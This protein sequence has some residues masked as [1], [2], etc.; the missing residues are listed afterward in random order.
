MK[1]SISID[2]DNYAEY[3]SLIDP[4]RPRGPSF[5]PDAL[6]RLLDLL[7]RHRLR[8]TFFVIG[9]DAAR[10]EHRGLLQQALSAGHELANH[11]FSHP[12]NFRALSPETRAGEIDRAGEA[13]AQATGRAPVG[14]RTPS[15]DVDGITLGLLEERGYAYDASVFPSPLMWVFRL[16]GRAV[17]RRGDYQL[18]E[19]RMALAPGE[20]YFPSRRCIH[21]GAT[22]PSEDRFDLPELPLSVA[23][24]L[25]I[26]FYSTL[27]RRGGAGLFRR[28]VGHHGRRARRLHALF[29]LVEAADLRG[30]PLEAA[31]RRS[32]GL[33][34]PLEA[35]LRFLDGAFAALAEAGESVTLAEVAGG[36]RCGGRAARPAGSDRSASG[37]RLPRIDEPPDAASGGGEARAG[38]R[39]RACASSLLGSTRRT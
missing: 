33:A 15:C 31:F 5:Y 19:V 36:L 24:P 11:S 8:A 34:L 23:T 35:R 2:L 27:L 9:R 14:F 32:P 16:Y 38:E 7:D 20:P 39:V 4:K 3:A 22:V 18:G 10:P 28:L 13:I 1:V 29:H 26:P 6:P 21:Q 25:R 17:V 37:Q 30:S 12:Y